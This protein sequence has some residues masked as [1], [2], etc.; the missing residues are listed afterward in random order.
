MFLL[1]PVEHLVL[2]ILCV[3]TQSCYSAIQKLDVFKEEI[4][5]GSLC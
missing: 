4:A 1:S 5:V 3:S 2:S